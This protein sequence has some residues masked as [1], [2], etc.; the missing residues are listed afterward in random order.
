MAR[1]ESTGKSLKNINLSVDNSYSGLIKEVKIEIEGVNFE[2]IEINGKEG[3]NYIGIIP[4]TY[5]SIKNVKF[6]N[7][8]INAKSN[9]VG[10]I[11]SILKASILDVEMENVNINANSYVGGLVGQAINGTINNL[12]VKEV[13]VNGVDYIGGVAGI[14]KKTVDSDGYSRIQIE[15]SNIIGRN[16]CGWNSRKGRRKNNRQHFET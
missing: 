6:K 10:C 16:L 15:Y 3:N 12:L 4:S 13:N 5:A 2:D 9:Y 1:L 8:I 7:I 11:G 14:Q